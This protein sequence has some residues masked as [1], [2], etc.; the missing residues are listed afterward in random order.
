MYS[1]WIPYVCTAY[2]CRR[3][4]FAEDDA[5]L[6]MCVGCAAGCVDIQPDDKRQ[7]TARQVLQ[8]GHLDQAQQQPRLQLT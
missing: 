4:R 2:I 6:A 1:S 5:V 3:S 8:Q 7:M